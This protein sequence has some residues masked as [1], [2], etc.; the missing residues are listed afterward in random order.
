MNVTKKP[1]FRF[2]NHPKGFRIAKT[3]LVGFIILRTFFAVH[4]IYGY[5]TSF[6]LVMETLPK[7]ENFRIGT[8]S[9]GLQSVM[10]K[11][12]NS[13][14]RK[15]RIFRGSLENLPWLIIVFWISET[16]RRKSSQN[17]VYDKI[18]RVIERYLEE[19]S[20]LGFLDIQG[21]MM[22]PSQKTICVYF[23][24]F[25][26]IKIKCNPMHFVALDELY[27]TVIRLAKGVQM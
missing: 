27:K 1:F 21:S 3:L 18:L 6:Y 15:P 24:H 8:N 9:Y 5:L 20:I 10:V 25:I 13:F 23:W 26:W 14:P 19:L 12:E 2:W 7:A 16:A 22:I 11:I 17:C 4:V